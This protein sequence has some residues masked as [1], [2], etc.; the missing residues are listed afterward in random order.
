MRATTTRAVPAGVEFS[1]RVPGSPVTFA[2]VDVPPGGPA[3]DCTIAAEQLLT[4]TTD[5]DIGASV[6]AEIG[7]RLHTK[8]GIY[9]ACGAAPSTQSC[10][11]VVTVVDSF[12][13][14]HPIPLVGAVPA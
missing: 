6:T 9:P 14:A 4:C 3:I 8:V 7:V 10:V 13:T 12:T 5:D 1:V 11:P 2:S